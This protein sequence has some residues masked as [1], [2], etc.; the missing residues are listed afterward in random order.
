MRSE[1]VPGAFTGSV[2]CSPSYL[3]NVTSERT[4]FFGSRKVSVGKLSAK[5]IKKSQLLLLK[6][7]N[8][9]A[10]STLKCFLWR[11]GAA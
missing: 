10:F 4:E 7:K 3:G 2:Y 9:D 5:T 6:K 11:L 1:K 8:F